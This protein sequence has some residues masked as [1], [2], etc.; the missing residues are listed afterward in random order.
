MLCDSCG[1]SVEVLRLQNRALRGIV[2]SLRTRGQRQSEKTDALFIALCDNSSRAEQA[3][4]ELWEKAGF[5]CSPEDYEFIVSMAIRALNT[6]HG[7]DAS[8]TSTNQELDRC[9]THIA[10]EGWY[11]MREVR[12]T[13]PCAAI[14]TRVCATP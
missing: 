8:G 4:R 2:R 3:L 1:E 14:P 6:V 5:Q 13:G 9:G 7:E 11:C 10:P 12:H